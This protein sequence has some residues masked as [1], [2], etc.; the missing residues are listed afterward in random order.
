[1]VHAKGIDDDRDEC[2]KQIL[3]HMPELAE[4]DSR[5]R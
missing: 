2:D 1:M 3:L 4:R 5:V